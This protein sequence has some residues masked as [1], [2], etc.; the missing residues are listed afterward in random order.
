M[1]QLLTAV[2]LDMEVRLDGSTILT[3]DLL[4]LRPGDVLML[5]HPLNREAVGL[6]N[7]SPKFRG[8]VRVVDDVS[9]FKVSGAFQ[10]E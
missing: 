1:A 3:R 5:N 6:V 8:D 2:N 4:D 9:G 10:E 7:G